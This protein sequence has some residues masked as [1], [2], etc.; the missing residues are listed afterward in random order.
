MNAKKCD[1]CGAFYL[2][3]TPNYKPVSKHVLS[4]NVDKRIDMAMDLCPD[5]QK[6][7]EAWIN[8]DAVIDMIA[9]EE[10]LSE[11]EGDAE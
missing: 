5:C 9:S 10:P 6:S 11:E 3:G 8:G 2:D 4:I 1:I 7:L